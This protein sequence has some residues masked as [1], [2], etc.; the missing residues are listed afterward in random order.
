MDVSWT[1]PRIPRTASLG[2]RMVAFTIDVLLA[3][4]IFIGVALVV[5][6]ATGAAATFQ[7]AIELDPVEIVLVTL[8]F[9]TILLYF[10]V[11]EARSGTTV[12]KR[13][14]DLRTVRADGEPISLLDSFI[15]NVLRFLW[16]VPL[17]GLVFL[18]A[19]IYLVYK[20]ELD[21]RIGDLGA[22]TVVVQ[23]A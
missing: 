5:L 2:V 7:P 11:F 4:A 15:R 12:G 1:R 23:A 18:V 20:G 8:L 21:Q 22:G 3:T 6:V 13:M 9:P 14:L 10:T 16:F 17:V 19:D